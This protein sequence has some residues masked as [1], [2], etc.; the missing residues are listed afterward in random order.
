[1]M[2]SKIFRC[3]EVLLW[4]PALL[5]RLTPAILNAGYDNDEESVQV[6]L[7]LVRLLPTKR[8]KQQICRHILPKEYREDFR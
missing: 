6:T 3:F 5:C 8:K 7:L 4:P 1:M 2:L